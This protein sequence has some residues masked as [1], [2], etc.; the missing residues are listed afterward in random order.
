M[1]YVANYDYIANV[2]CINKDKPK[3]KCNGKCYL[4]QQLAK[5]AAEDDSSKENLPV[6]VDFQLLYFQEISSPL[7]IL[8]SSFIAE[9]QPVFFAFQ[10]Y[11]TRYLDSLFRP[12]ILG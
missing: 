3:L 11:K 5:N 7:T 9:K 10:G 6:K 2:L 12:P 1:D 8:S 4:M